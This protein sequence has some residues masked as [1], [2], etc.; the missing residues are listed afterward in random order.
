MLDILEVFVINSMLNCSYAL[1]IGEE[2]IAIKARDDI[3]IK[4]FVKGFL[5]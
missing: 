5:R 2:M 3:V 4:T 1:E